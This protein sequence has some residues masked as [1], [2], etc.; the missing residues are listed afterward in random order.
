M[1][2]YFAADGNAAASSSTAGNRWRV[3]FAPNKTGEWAYRA[4]M[5]KGFGVAVKSDAQ[6]S[7]IAGIDGDTGTFKIAASA[8]QGVDFRAKGRLAYVG[9]H[10]LRFAGNNEYF[11]KAGADS[12]ETLL[13][14]E[15]FDGTITRKVPLKKYTPHLGDWKPGDP[16]WKDGKGKV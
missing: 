8:K 6:G 10:Y 11:L 1:P 14:H 9:E 7:P 15:D 13:A 2:G 16:A 3:H 4:S 12:P 5:V